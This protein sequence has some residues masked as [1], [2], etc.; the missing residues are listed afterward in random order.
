MIHQIMAFVLFLSDARNAEVKIRAVIRRTRRS[1]I[2]AVTNAGIISSLLR[3]M[4][5]NDFLLL[6]SNDPIAK[7]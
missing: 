7:V 3:L 6:R 5:K 1:G 2:T 4:M